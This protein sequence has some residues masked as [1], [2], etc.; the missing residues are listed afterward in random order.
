MARTDTLSNYLTDVADAIRE[1]KGT[2]DKIVASTFDEEIKNLPSGGG[3]ISDYISSTFTGSS[4]YNMPAIAGALLKLPDD[5]TIDGYDG[6]YLFTGCSKLTT[7]PKIDTSNLTTAYAMF[8]GCS[9]LTSIPLID[10]SNVETMSSMFERCWALTSIPQLDTS[11]VQGMDNMFNNC[12]SLTTIPQLDTSNVQSINGMF[13]NCTSLTTIPQL[14]TSNVNNFSWA[15]YNCTSL[16]TIPQLDMSGA[17][18]IQY[19]FY[20]ATGFVSIPELNC[21]IVMYTTGVLRAD[22]QPSALTTLGGFKDLGKGY[23]SDYSEHSDE[24]SLDLTLGFSYN[25]STN[26]THDSLM[27]VINDLY[28]IKTAGY[29]NQYVKLTQGDYAKLTTDEIAIATNKGWDIIHD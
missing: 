6:Q 19:S 20:N 9:A 25:D 28:D 5:I 23:T 11:N 10:T 26:L 8:A 13:S 12:T 17:V 14:N 24:H 16:T 4:Q 18:D 29:A 21:G 3:D 1:K 22:S 27:N 15:F 2:T 7:I